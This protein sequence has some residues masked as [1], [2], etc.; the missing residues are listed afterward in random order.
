M[1]HDTL[2]EWRALCAGPN[3]ASLDCLITIERRSALALIDQ[4]L[5]LQE[6]CSAAQNAIAAIPAALETARQA[7]RRSGWV[8][9]VEVAAM[10]ARDA[11]ESGEDGV[12]AAVR[13]LN[14][15]AAEGRK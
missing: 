6:V 3:G 1:T 12:A 5:A 10:T 9:G 11:W 15:S 13:A 2:A 14:P 7:G 4:V 8:I